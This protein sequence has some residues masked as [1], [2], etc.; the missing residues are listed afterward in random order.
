MNR[1]P[2]LQV[3]LVFPLGHRRVNHKTI[4]WCLDHTILQLFHCPIAS[5][6]IGTGSLNLGVMFG[7]PF[8]IL[9]L[10]LGKLLATL[11]IL[12]N[13]KIGLLQL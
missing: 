8:V 5:R 12:Q 7:G 2:D 6:V 13:V 3:W 4:T 11:V 9:A 1:F 10:Q